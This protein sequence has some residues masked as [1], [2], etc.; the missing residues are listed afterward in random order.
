MTPGHRIRCSGR[1]SAQQIAP[2]YEY[3]LAYCVCGARL[4]PCFGGSPVRDKVGWGA[5]DPSIYRDRLLQRAR[6]RPLI[7][8]S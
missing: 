6:L 2:S 1:R 3:V 7:V 8:H 4:S 5:S